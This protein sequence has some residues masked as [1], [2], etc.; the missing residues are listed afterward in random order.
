[1]D[2]AGY[3]P[4]RIGRRV[5]RLRESKQMTIGQF[6]DAAD[7]NKNTIVRLEK[8][9]K[10]TSLDTIYKVCKVLN[11]S[12]ATLLEE[13]LISRIDYIVG[14]GPKTRK[15]KYG[16]RNKRETI[17]SEGPVNIGDLHL[18]LDGGLMHAGVIEVTGKS[19]ERI[20]AGEEL[21]FCLTGKVELAVSGEK[22][23][24]NKGDGVVFLGGDPHSYRYLEGKNGKAVCLSVLVC[25]QID[26]LE[27]FLQKN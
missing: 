14:E 4:S 13:K 12:V 18:H 22:L 24:L 15:I 10:Q 19:E 2:S 21:I 16:E 27:D 3:D 6:S 9:D 25:D 1:M 5:R 26:N 11:I 7:V 17:I 20:H 23:Q 8:G